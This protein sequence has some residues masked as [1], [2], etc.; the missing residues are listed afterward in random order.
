MRAGVLRAVGVQAQGV[1]GDHEA[2]GFGHILLALLDLRVI[3]LFNLAA[4]QTHHVVVVL[5]LVQLI[6]GFTTF[7]MIA[8][9]QAR[10]RAKAAV[11]GCFPRNPNPFC[12]PWPS[13]AWCCTCF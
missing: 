12:L 10:V 6:N 2:F 8:A 7:K 11:L 9:E 3:K 5:P 4:V 13:W 1:V